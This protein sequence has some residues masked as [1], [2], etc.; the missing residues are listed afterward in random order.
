MAGKLTSNWR[1]NRLIILAAGVIL[2]IVL[3]GF[4][5]KNLLIPE[6]SAVSFSN[7]KLPGSF[8][9]D[10]PKYANTTLVSS[11]SSED[12]ARETGM[13]VVWQT[14][15][16]SEQ[17]VAFYKSELPKNGWE[18]TTSF[19]QEKSE[20]LSFEKGEMSGFM[21]V[22]GGGVTHISVTLGKEKD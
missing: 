4:L 7:S 14:P 10:F 9:S 6:E 3:G 20:T 5:G 16:T 15:D 8:P 2:L 17:V 19:G 1:R 21:G 11:W 12:K 13:S 22:T 18:I